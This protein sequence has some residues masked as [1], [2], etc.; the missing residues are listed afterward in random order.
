[1]LLTCAAAVQVRLFYKLP[2]IAGKNIRTMRTTLLLLTALSLLSAAGKCRKNA[3]G[4][5]DTSPLVSLECGPCFGYCPVFKLDVL[6]NGHV[7]YEGI[8]FAEKIGK[9]SFNLNADELKQLKDKVK[10]ANLWQHPDLIK[11]NV[12][13]APFATLTTW[14]EGKSKS[15]KGSIDR[16]KTLLELE[17]MLKDLAGAHGFEVKRGVNPNDVPEANRR[18][19]LVKLKPDVNAGNWVRQFTEFKLQLVRRVSEENIWRVAYDHK[20]VDEKTVMET[21]KNSAGVLDVQ[22]NQQVQDRN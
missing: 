14:Q 15:V 10:E 2:T 12:A 17:G 22:P 13:D 7:R 19:V 4:G 20:Q 16:P 3:S 5:G 6:N 11:T 18:E 8:R 9:D 21:L 1:M